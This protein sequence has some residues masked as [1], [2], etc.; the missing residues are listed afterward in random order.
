MPA[1]PFL[2]GMPGKLL[3]AK[4]AGSGCRT[5]IL[6]LTGWPYWQHFCRQLAM[7]MWYTSDGWRPE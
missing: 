7:C 5:G 6:A 4:C 2:L 1:L 3:A